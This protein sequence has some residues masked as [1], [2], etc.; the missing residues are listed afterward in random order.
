[1]LLLNSQWTGNKEFADPAQFTDHTLNTTGI[2]D[3]LWAKIWRGNAG[4]DPRM[5]KT[6][7]T[8]IEDTDK[9]KILGSN[10]A[11]PDVE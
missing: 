8:D 10:S 6:L 1:M 9:E 5:R 2:E 7:S 3:P 11:I 4:G